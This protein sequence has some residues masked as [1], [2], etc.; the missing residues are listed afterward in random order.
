MEQF[1]RTTQ[2]IYSH[3]TT[4]EKSRERTITIMHFH[5]VN[6]NTEKTVEIP[7]NVN[8]IFRSKRETYVDK[9]FILCNTVRNLNK[10]ILNN[11]AMFIS[12]LKVNVSNIFTLL[13][14]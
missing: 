10:T 2:D 12:A 1:D 5:N 4:T 8:T 11:V 7:V 3:L 13:Q 9:I 6:K 14:S